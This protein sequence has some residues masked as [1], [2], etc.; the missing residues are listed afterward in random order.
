M[1]GGSAAL[2]FSASGFELLD[3]DDDGVELVVEVQTSTPVVGCAECG[4]RATPKDRR[5]VTLRDAPSGDRAARLRWRKRIW[6]CADPDCEVRTWTE[7]SFMAGPRRMLTTRAGEW[8]T[9]RVAALEGTPSS[10]AQGLRRVVVDGVVS[11]R[12]HCP[13][14]GRRRR[15]GRLGGHGGLRRD[16][17][18][19]ASRRRRRRFAVVDVDSGQLL[20][21][22]WAAT[23]A[24]CGH[25]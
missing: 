6:S 14:A 24:T 7:Q 4:V 17:H 1:V 20:D 2:W 22:F 10:I 25:G 15:P 18:N 5:W 3:V 21:V 16:G 8:A 12:A 11:R 13:G 9:R 19:P 23:P